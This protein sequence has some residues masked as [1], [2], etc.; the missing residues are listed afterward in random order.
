M[1]SKTGKT[2]ISVFVR[3]WLTKLWVDRIGLGQYW[4]NAPAS[5]LTWIQ[6]DLKYAFIYK[7]KVYGEVR[8]IYKYKMYFWSIYWLAN[9][10]VVFICWQN[11]SNYFYKMSQNLK[12]KSFGF[13]RL[14]KTQFGES[15][16]NLM[17]V[18]F[19]ILFG[20]PQDRQS[21]QLNQ[22]KIRFSQNCQNKI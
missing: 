15:G 16:V 20:M 5:G 18:K 12:Q 8:F 9:P 22:N 2:V 21:I 17:I 4:P 7:Y 6:I 19:S 10:E 3:P 13:F 1:S 14:V 11:A